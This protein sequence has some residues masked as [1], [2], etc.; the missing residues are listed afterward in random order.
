[1]K[2]PTSSRAVSIAFVLLLGSAR[3]WGHAVIVESTPKAN[4]VISGPTLQIKVRFNARIDSKRSK[5]TLMAPDGAL[6]AIPLA[7]QVSADSLMANVS[8][9]QSGKYQLHW[10]VL[11]SDG[12]ISQGD[13]SFS[14]VNP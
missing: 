5:L 9:L 7:Q 4:D 12:H 14:V 1:M 6:R 3:L 11:A 10:Q 13:I 8:N 2:Q